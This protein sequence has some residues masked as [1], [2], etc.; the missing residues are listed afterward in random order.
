MNEFD[1][2]NILGDQA[3]DYLDHLVAGTVPK[4]GRT[5]LGHALTPMGKVYAELTLTCLPDNKGFMIV[6]GSGS[7][8]HDL[9][10]LQQVFACDLCY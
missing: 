4:E 10:H 6:T 1:F 7:E 2:F 9:R 5:S 8:L 3:R